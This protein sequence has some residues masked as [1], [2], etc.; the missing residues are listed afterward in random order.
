MTTWRILARRAARR[1]SVPGGN[2]QLL[3]AQH[4]ALSRQIPVLYAIILCSIW[5][6][7]ATYSNAAPWWLTIAIPALFTLGALARAILWLRPPKAGLGPER[8]HAELVRTNRLAAGIA[9][10]FAGWAFL[11]FP[12]GDA[13]ARS[14]LAFSTAITFMA[15]I[16]CMRQLRSSILI[17]TLIVNVAFGAFFAAT[18]E[19]A[20]IAIAAHL[21]LVSAGMLAV[22]DINYHI[23]ARMVNAQTETRRQSEAQTR[24]LRMIDDMP[25]AV[26][27]VEP[28]TL[29]VNYA[30]ETSKHLI[31][32]IE[33]LLPI[34]AGELLGTSIDVFHHDPQHQRRILADPANLPHSARIQLGPEVLDL[35]VSA[36]TA[37]DGS[38]LGPMLT[39]A[40][41]TKEAEAQRRIHQLAHFDSLT[42]LANRATFHERLEE[43]IAAA[44]RPVAL[45]LID[46]DGFKFINDT[47]GHRAGDALLRQVADR[48]RQACGRPGTTVARLG[49]D[50]FAVLHPHG[51]AGESE[52]LC[53]WLLQALA[54]PYELEGIRHLGLG[55]CIG[56][57]LA[58]ADG[59]SGQTLLARADMALH[60]A[61][62]AG[63][64]LFR[65]FSIE[66]ETSSQERTRLQTQLAQALRDR[67]GL[68]VF[69]Q[70]IMDVR[71][72]AV[73]AREA[74]ARWHQPARGWV[75]PAAFVPVAE[76]G[77]L[78]EPLGEFVLETACRDAAE[79]T[80]GARVA[81]NVSAAQL[82]RGTLGPAVR[83]ALEASG[84]AAY[85]LEVEVTE[86]ALLGDGQEVIADLRRLREMGVRVA[87]DDFGTGYSSLSHLRAFP[88]DKI[89][90]DGLFVKDA[91]ARPECAAVVGAIAA[92]GKRL[93]VATVAEG[94]ETDADL[95]LARQEGCTEVQGY[96]LGR[97]SPSARMAPLVDRINQGG[98][99]AP[100]AFGGHAAVAST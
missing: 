51:G 14:H 12:Y 84:L 44:G 23:F 5:A 86:T 33:H 13:Y 70:P 63:K 54:A 16:F 15:C 47:Q 10:A 41:V 28:H 25:M 19:P 30:N 92:L 45:L 21:V 80:D 40:L 17:V 98:E 31:R 53:T 4:H 94:V 37:C 82:G 62:E 11:L 50:E 90:I 57:A 69:Y 91:L 3:E 87:L 65:R 26:M 73:V 9:L 75:S 43:C 7:A 56:M 29:K 58:P 71:T 18:G 22:L 27:T 42:G 85:R 83:R 46:L 52:A 67:Q 8:A 20:F 32:S 74:L 99:P 6:L 48:L 88:F 35:K 2:P 38:Y 24:L 77:G 95:E 66:M 96:L 68:F 55:A 78:I 1:L 64:G 49:G 100:P 89:K 93:G 34:K 61:K 72:R 81:V 97:P 39:W 76:Q 60:A 59:A 36:I 79:W